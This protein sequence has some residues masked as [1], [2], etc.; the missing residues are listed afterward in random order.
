MRTIYYYLKLRYLM[1]RKGIKQFNLSLT[2]NLPKW[3]TYRELTLLIE[4]TVSMSDN[5]LF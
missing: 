3:Q 1:W 5:D 4:D 2:G